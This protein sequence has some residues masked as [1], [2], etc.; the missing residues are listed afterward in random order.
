MTANGFPYVTA[1]GFPYVT[2]NGFPYMA[3]NGF[4]SMTANGFPY[5][6]AN[7]FPYMYYMTAKGTVYF[8]HSVRF[9]TNSRAKPPTQNKMMSFWRVDIKSFQT[10]MKA[11]EWDKLFTS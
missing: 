5:M 11:S 3:G 10:K 8:N 7:R 4:P 2:D 1:N 6:T 9:S